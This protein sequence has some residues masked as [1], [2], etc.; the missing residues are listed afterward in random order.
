[1][2]ELLTAIVIAKDE[3]DNLPRCLKSLVGLADSVVVC[4]TGS[5]DGTQDIARALGALL[6]ERPWKDSF[7]ASKNEALDAATG[8][9]VLPIDCDEEVGAE[10]DKAETRERLRDDGLP[11]IKLVRNVLRYP[12]Y[13]V[14]LLMPRLFRRKAG[15]RFI[16]DVHE[17]LDVE[18]E[19]AVLSNVWLYHHGYLEPGAL[20]KKERRNLR[21]ALRMPPSG[22]RDHCVARSAFAVGEWREAID[23]CRSLLEST[24]SPPLREDACSI[25]AAASFNARDATALA[26]FLDMGREMAPESADIQLIAVLDAMARYLHLLRNG[27]STTQGLE[28]VRPWMFWHEKTR[29]RRA[30]AE[31]SNATRS[32]IPTG[33]LALP[34]PEGDSH[35]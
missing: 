17:Q 6:I 11:D 23:A 32:P 15:I 7:A 29:A 10:T 25:G 14:T 24:T 12:T 22:H 18:D 16:H 1:M 19:T 13:S 2:P 8:E 3:A 27:D 31:M 35:A 9:H 26:A 21:I 4:D 28:Y 20:E 5:T 33:Q 34:T 30:F